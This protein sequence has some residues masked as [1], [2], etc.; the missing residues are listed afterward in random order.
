MTYNLFFLDNGRDWFSCA[1]SSDIPSR[2][3]GST[4][5]GTFPLGLGLGRPQPERVFI[6][7][8]RCWL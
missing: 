7:I 8:P 5:F 6:P 4:S 2:F 1:S 3:F